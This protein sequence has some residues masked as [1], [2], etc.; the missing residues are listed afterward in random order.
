MER[1][2]AQSKY[3]C[4][5]GVPT[6]FKN[7]QK[8]LNFASEASDGNFQKTL[9]YTFLPLINSFEFLQILVIYSIKRITKNQK[10]FSRGKKV[11]PKVFKVVDS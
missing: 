4:M 2:K 1:N 7:Y 6:V 11:S 5:V 3:Y 9:G 8:S 10:E